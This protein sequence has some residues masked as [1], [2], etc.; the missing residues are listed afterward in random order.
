MKPGLAGTRL[1]VMDALDPILTSLAVAACGLL[2]LLS[3]VL[4]KQLDWRP[5]DRPRR[6]WSHRP[7]DPNPRA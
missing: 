1:D 3:G 4:K 6:P 2:M 5:R 7:R